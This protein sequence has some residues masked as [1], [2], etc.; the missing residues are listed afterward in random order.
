MARRY[1]VIAAVLVAIGVAGFLLPS[2]LFGVFEVTMVLNAWH[3]L[4]GVAAAIAATRGVGTMRSWGQGLGYVFA[5]LTVAGFVMEPE[6][7]NYM[8]PLSTANAWFHLLVTLV[9]L[10]HAL[11]APPTL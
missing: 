1:Y 9:F 6:T 10:Y 2:P 8:L 7:V 11:L 4:A 3:V 5:A